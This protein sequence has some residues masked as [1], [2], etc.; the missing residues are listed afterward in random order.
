MASLVS[1]TTHPAPSSRYD[2]GV[3]SPSP[4]SS[5]VVDCAVYVDGIRQ[6]GH[7]D[8]TAAY[9]HVRDTGEGFVWLGLLAPT[10]DQMTA[11]A[12]VFGLHHLVVEDLVH[13]HQRPKLELYD[14]VAFLVLRSMHYVDNDS[15]DRANDVVDGGEIM[16]ISSKDFVITVRHGDHTALAGV[17]AALEAR[18]TALAYGPAA[19]VHNI[20]DHVVDTYVEVVEAMQSDVDDLEERVFAVSTADLDIDVVY[21]FKRE[22]LELRRAVVPLS[23]PLAWLSGHQHAPLARHIEHHS[24]LIGG[25]REEEIRRHFRDVADHLSTV[26]DMVNEYDERLSSLL[27]AAATKVNIQQSTDMRK[28]SSWAALAAVPT[29]IAGI[30]GMN[31]EFMPELDWDFS[32]PVIL[33][34]MG[35]VCFL[36]WRTLHRHKWL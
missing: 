10:E 11:V 31:F 29:M 5:A 30:Y 35:S 14:G 8:Y 17:R 34:I 18:P 1:E 22:V 4:G 32:Y 36:L 12:E 27:Q 21:L 24:D 2:R 9:R 7:D 33:L 19:V 16:V 23:G 6:P 20:A 28:I 25:H 13:A 15:L 3:R 26:I